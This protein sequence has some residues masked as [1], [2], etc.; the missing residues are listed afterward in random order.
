MLAALR[1]EE[2]D[3]LRLALT[4]QD[5]VVNEMVFCGVPFS[6][7]GYRG[8]SPQEVWQSAYGT[9]FEKACLLNLML[10][11]VKIQSEIFVMVPSAYPQDIVSP[12]LWEDFAVSVRPKKGEQIY[13]SVRELNSQSLLLTAVGKKFLPV[14][15][16]NEFISYNGDNLVNLARLDISG[17]I[18]GDFTLEADCDVTM[19]GGCVPFLEMTRSA[20]KASSYI[21][22]MGRNA[23]KEGKIEKAGPTHCEAETS[24][25]KAIP[26]KAEGQYLFLNLPFPEK[27]LN[28]WHLGELPESRKQPF[29]IPF[30]IREELSLSLELPADLKLLSPSLDKQISNEA[31]SMHISLVVRGD[32]LVLEKYIVLNKNTFGPNYY[33]GLREL[34]NNW[35]S[36]GNKELVFKTK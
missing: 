2:K 1:K 15:G 27:G 4:L 10:R 14:P 19:K 36:K 25:D 30:P 31:G 21:G 24:T 33:T 6:M 11:A 20:V 23:L 34:L 26:L 12:G 3:D 7:P 8:R 13:L 32:K 18:K 9:A 28:A 17:S 29:D 16:M 5:K 35:N 22:G